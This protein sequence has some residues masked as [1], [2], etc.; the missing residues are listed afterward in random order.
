MKNG[1]KIGWKVVSK[2]MQS[3]TF[4]PDTARVTYE[5]NK[6][7]KPRAKCGPLTVFTNLLTALE[8]CG[9]H[10][11]IFMCYFIPSTFADMFYPRDNGRIISQT[12]ESARTLFPT[13]ELANE[14]ELMLEV[15]R[16]TEKMDFEEEV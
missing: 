5:L 10:E 8:Y 7:V 11:R 4:L 3:P 16:L 6:P 13:I 14:V 15:T 9:T 1:W 2:D 12:L